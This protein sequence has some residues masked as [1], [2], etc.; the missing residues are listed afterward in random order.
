MPNITRAMLATALDKIVSTYVQAAIAF[1]L[2][3]DA[4]DMDRAEAAALAAVPA[5]L[6]AFGAFLS[7]IPD[8]TRQVP[9]LYEVVARAARTFLASWVGLMVAGWS[10]VATLGNAGDLAESAAIAAIP[11]V[12]SVVK[13]LVA[14]RM[15]QR[16][17]AAMVPD[18]L[19]V[20]AAARPVSMPNA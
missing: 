6:T 18:R 15:A 13:S 2:T 19:D 9:F 4:L 17:T 8:A 5:A 3:A 14:S 12:L 20:S 11:A 1:M 10:G 7:A 16:D